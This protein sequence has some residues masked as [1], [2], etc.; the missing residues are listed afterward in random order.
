MA[1]V[2]AAALLVLAL[3]AW[4][5]S[6]GPSGVLTG[7][8]FDPVATPSAEPSATTTAS[9]ATTAGD[10]PPPDVEVRDWVRVVALLLQ[11]AVTLV[12]AYLL[13]RYV[14]LPALRWL[15]GRLAARR[16][17]RAAEADAGLF[18]VL[19]PPAAVAREM[20]AGAAAQREVLLGTASPRNAVVACWHR[21]ET[22][23]AAAGVGR[24][25]WET[26]AEYTMRVLDLVDA[27]Q[28][29]VSRLAELYREARFSEH[30]LT[31]QHRADALAALDDIHRTTGMP[32]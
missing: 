6:S 26:S 3:A 16:R 29:A 1:A 5:S 23:A 18:T 30:D 31:E 4:A 32:A 19:E 13:L 22:Q 20:A 21:F 8:G 2:V 15:R 11:V 12:A 17:E 14:G 28:P 9:E 25:P 27:H 7:E 24:H 10:E